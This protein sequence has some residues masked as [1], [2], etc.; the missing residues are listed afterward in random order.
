MR[1]LDRFIA[2]ISLSRVLRLK[3]Y[4]NMGLQNLPTELQ[5]L[6]IENLECDREINAL[7]RTGRYFYNMLNPLLYK[8]SG[9]WALLRAARLGRL[10]TAQV[11]LRLLLQLGNA[12]GHEVDEPL[13]VAS[14]EGHVDMVRLFLQHKTSINTSAFDL[15]E[16]LL[17]AARENR[18]DVVRLLLDNG[19]PVNVTG[20]YGSVLW[21]V[22]SWGRV[23]MVELLLDYRAEANPPGINTPL[24]AAML[25][26]NDEIIRLLWNAGARPNSRTR[27]IAICCPVNAYTIQLVINHGVTFDREDF[28]RSTYNVRVPPKEM[29]AIVKVVRRHC[30]QRKPTSRVWEAVRQFFNVPKILR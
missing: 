1:T 12:S 19:A 2:E 24:H 28:N 20:E 13:R 10:V 30:R 21:E 9:S 15:A 5:L 8:Q 27:E 23:E 26:C 16:P 29:K 17:C 4:I 11:A 6:I 22:S 18:I 14:K 25:C 3:H 7:A